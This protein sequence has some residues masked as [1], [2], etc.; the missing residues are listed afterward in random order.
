MNNISLSCCLLSGL[1]L[2][3]CSDSKKSNEQAE[4]DIE[5]EVPSVT[6]SL[7]DTEK[8][9]GW[10]LLFDGQDISKWKSIKTAEF[11]SDGWIIEDGTM[12]VSGKKGG[13]DIITREK[14]SD[15]ELTFEFMLT[16]S[17]NSGIKY[18]VG[19][20]NNKDKAGSTIF[21]G[22]EYQIIDDSQHP[23]VTD[24]EKG[25]L[26]STGS[27]YL[28]YS[29]ENKNLLPAGEWNTG[30]IVAR[31]KNVEHWLNDA[32]ILSYERGNEDFR[33]RVAGTKFKNQENYGELESGHIMLTDHS[34]KVYFKNIRIRRL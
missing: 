28:L 17:A 29:P 19:E 1:L 15:F 21:N 14:Y 27:L 23:A 13:D 7:T 22:P 9:E 6:V 3:G 8:A 4:A 11:P 18:F 16:D 26:I 5:K 32:K 10:E 12:V 25:N 20:M 33:N 2:A 31:G 34:D 24:D 30:K